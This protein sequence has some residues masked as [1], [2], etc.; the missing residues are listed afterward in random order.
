VEA[1]KIIVTA[2]TND[3]FRV[4]GEFFKIPTHVDPARADLAP[5]APLLCSS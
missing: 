4:E 2:L 3:S 1:A 5:R